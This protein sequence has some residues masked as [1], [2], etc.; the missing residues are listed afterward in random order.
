MT[1]QEL[2]ETI[3][4]LLAAKGG[5]TKVSGS[6]GSTDLH[7]GQLEAVKFRAGEVVLEF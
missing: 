4:N 1:L 7:G 2:Y 3:A 5:E 6:W